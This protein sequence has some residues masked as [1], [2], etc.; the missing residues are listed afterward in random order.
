MARQLD[1]HSIDGIVTALYEIISGPAGERDWDADRLL[2]LPDARVIPARS[3][4]P[5][6]APPKTTDLEGYILSRAPWFR[7]HD[8]WEDEVRREV[9]EFGGFAHVLSSY[10]ALEAPGGEPILRGINSIQMS[11]DGERWWIVSLVWDN[12]RPGLSLPERFRR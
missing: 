12:E 11:H 3:S 7:E 5:G 4:V 8:L 1:V 2:F 6:V 9:F 10:V